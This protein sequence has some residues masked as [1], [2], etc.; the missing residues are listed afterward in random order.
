MFEK[1]VFELASKV[2]DLVEDNKDHQ[3]DSDR[4]GELYE[5]GIVDEDGFLIQRLEETNYHLKYY[6]KIK[7]RI[8]IDICIPS[9]IVTRLHL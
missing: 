1:K 9:Q 3:K 4:L 8:T 6:F 5:A 7:C 2:N